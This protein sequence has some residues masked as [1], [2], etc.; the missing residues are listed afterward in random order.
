MIALRPICH[1]AKCRKDGWYPGDNERRIRQQMRDDGWRSR[2]TG[3]H[4]EEF[5]CGECNKT[6]ALVAANSL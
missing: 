3:R 5:T 1:N 4:S 6:V 2:V